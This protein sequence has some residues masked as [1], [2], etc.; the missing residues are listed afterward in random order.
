MRKLI[1]I[2]LIVLFPVIGAYVERPIINI[3]KQLPSAIRTQIQC[4]ADNIYFEARGEDTAG[5]IAVALVT[6]NRTRSDN[7]PSTVCSVVKQRVGQVC[8]F[9]WYCNHA[10]RRDHRITMQYT[11]IRRLAADI[12]LNTH[13][14][15]DITRGALF[16]HAEYVSKQRL[17]GVNIQK[18][19]QIGRH[20]FYKER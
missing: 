16:Y 1:F 17:G 12:Y 11:F 8:Q 9:T 5:Q 18:T 19:A 3:D 10:A 6:L 14:Y 7:F 2:V 13:R 20:I 15:G 4:L